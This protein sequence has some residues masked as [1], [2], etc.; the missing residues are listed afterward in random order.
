MLLG[1]QFHDRIRRLWTAPN[2]GMIVREFPTPKRPLIAGLK[3]HSKFSE[4]AK[5]WEQ[6]EYIYISLGS[7]S[8]C[9]IWSTDFHGEA[10]T[11]DGSLP[12]NQ[13]AEGFGQESPVGDSSAYVI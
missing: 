12:W 7:W 11:S 6:S 13:G 10:E 3:I 5:G 2:A 9:L 1:S 4:N 8:S